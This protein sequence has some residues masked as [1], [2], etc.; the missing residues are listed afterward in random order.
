MVWLSQRNFACSRASISCFV[1][2]AFADYRHCKYPCYVLCTHGSEV[3]C[4]NP[5]CDSRFIWGD[6]H[7]L[8]LV[9]VSARTA[10]SRGKLTC[11]WQLWKYDALEPL[12]GHFTQ[13]W[14]YSSPLT[15]LKPASCSMHSHGADM[16]QT[17]NSSG[18]E[19]ETRSL[20]FAEGCRAQ[21]PW[22]PHSSIFRAAERLVP[23]G[24]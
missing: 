21:E 4:Q 19:S 15:P 12:R 1:E 20:R 9:A 17:A 14:P 7:L 8:Y 6:S 23:R 3:Y 18:K 16:T 5:G 10:R 13:C 11:D 24:S 2:R 22:G